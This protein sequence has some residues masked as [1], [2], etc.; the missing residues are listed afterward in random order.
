MQI[1][2]L[3]A[4]IAPIEDLF[5]GV[6]ILRLTPRIT[7]CTR[8]TSALSFHSSLNTHAFAQL[9][10]IRGVSGKKSKHLPP[11]DAMLGTVVLL[12]ILILL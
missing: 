1:L 12:L 5:L 8:I 4:G 3:F 9:L 2:F 11:A 6:V 7:S 10:L